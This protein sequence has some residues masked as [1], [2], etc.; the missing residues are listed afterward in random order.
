MTRRK[1][2]QRDR[3]NEKADLRVGCNSRAMN[4]G[5]VGA[6]PTWVTIKTYY[7]YYGVKI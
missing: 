5:G 1:R 3:L 2:K 6:A 4:P 7:K